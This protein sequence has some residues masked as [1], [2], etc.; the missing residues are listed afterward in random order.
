MKSV[1]WSTPAGELTTNQVCIAQLKLDKLHP[2]KII[3]WKFHIAPNL[4]NYDMIIGRDMLADLQI[5]LR[6][7]DNT[8]QCL[9]TELPFK[10]RTCMNASTFGVSNHTIDKDKVYR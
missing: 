3:K 8:V 5:N 10:S 7:S 1:T 9:G 6:F 4:G 2:D